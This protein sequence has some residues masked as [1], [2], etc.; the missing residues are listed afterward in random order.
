MDTRIEFPCIAE[1]VALPENLLIVSTE[2]LDSINCIEI[3]AIL[4]DLPHRTII[5]QV[6]FPLPRTSNIDGS[7]NINNLILNGKIGLPCLSSLL[8]NA[9]LI[10]SH[11]V[12]FHRQ[13]FRIKPLPVINKPWLCTKKDIRWPIEKKLEPN[14]TIYDLALAYHVP[15]WSTNRALFECLYL[16]QVFERCPELEALIQ[17]GLEPRQNYRAQISK[18]DESDL[19]KA[20]GFTWNPIES[21]WCRRLSAKEVIALPFPVEPIP[22]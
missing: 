15:V 18:T 22:D 10:I 3:G 11:D 19:A 16:S 4:F 17:N 12:T 6:T 14:Y 13:Q 2:L 21:V 8:E 9:D 1:T 7:T 5:T 20:A